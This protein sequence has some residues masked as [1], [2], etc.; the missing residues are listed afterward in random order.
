M[1]GLFSKMKMVMAILM[2]KTA[3]IPTQMS[4]QVQLKPVMDWTIIVMVSL[5]KMSPTPFIVIWM[6]MDSEIAVIQ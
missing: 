2:M 3:M 4:M 6:A 1:K 5:M